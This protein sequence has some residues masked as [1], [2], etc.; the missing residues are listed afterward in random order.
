[1]QTST[2]LTLAAA[3]LLTLGGCG[4]GAEQE[5][6]E[7]NM[8]APVGDLAPD[9]VIIY[10]AGTEGSLE[11][12]AM[13]SE[14]QRLQREGGSQA[15]GGTSGA[16]M[17]NQSST[18]GMAGASGEN[19]SASAGSAGGE[20]GNQ[21]SSAG[22][23]GGQAGAA[24]GMGGFDRDNDGRLSPAEYAIH[25][26]PSETAARQGATNDENPPFVSDEALNQVITSFRQLDKNGD[27]FLSAD[28]FQPKAR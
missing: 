14:V 4:D 25:T 7:A 22:M 27:F 9:A 12:N 11:M 23:N 2:K 19:Q 24:A 6:A 5:V 18:A 20:G 3:A 1:M 26:L 28:E 13:R 17:G 8:A 10:P 16:G 15:A 21:S